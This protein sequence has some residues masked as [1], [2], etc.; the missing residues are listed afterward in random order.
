MIRTTDKS[1]ASDIGPHTARRVTGGWVVS[2]LPRHL[3]STRQ[4]WIALR[5]AEIYCDR[6]E[7]GSVWW[8]VAAECE[9]EL[10]VPP[11]VLRQLAGGN[12]AAKVGA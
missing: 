6:P 5:L 10:R 3:L 9:R 12:R 1:M 4:A 8:G 11:R 7:P 2:W